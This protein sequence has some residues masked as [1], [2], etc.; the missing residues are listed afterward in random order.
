[1]ALFLA[2]A[3]AAGP[4]GG[5]SVTDAWVR[6]TTGADLSTAAYLTIANTTG[7]ADALLSVSSPAATSVEMH[8][9]SM[10]SMGMTGMQPISRIDVAAGATTTLEPGRMHLMVM[11]LGKALAVGDRIELDLVFEHAGRVVVEAEVRQG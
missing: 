4:G 1:M 9:T 3:C 5:V 7:Q 6:P 8:L 2:I 10:D 11:G